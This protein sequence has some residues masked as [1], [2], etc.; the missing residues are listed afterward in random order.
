MSSKSSTRVMIGTLLVRF[1]GAMFLALIVAPRESS[2]TPA[3]ASRNGKDCGF[4]HV[5]GTQGQS[6]P[7]L[8]NAGTYFKNVC[9]G[10]K[11]VMTICWAP[12]PAKPACPPS[13]VFPRPPG[14]GTFD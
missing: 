6:P 8:N 10:Q 14:C 9:M 13:G 1:T 3:F 7:V 2:A 4:C 11:G 5:A 12:A